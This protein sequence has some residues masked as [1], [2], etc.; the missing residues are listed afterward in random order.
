MEGGR[1][2][3]RGALSRSGTRCNVPAVNYITASA[4]PPL[5]PSRSSQPHL[6]AVPKMWMVDGCARTLHLALLENTR[7]EVRE[8]LWL[9]VSL[10]KKE[11]I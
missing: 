8:V 5:P 11:R 9:H 6:W 2:L 3:E 7:E 4:L 10:L 1:G